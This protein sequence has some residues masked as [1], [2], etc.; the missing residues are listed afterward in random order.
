MI[1]EREKKII[2]YISKHGPVK[3]DEL[4]LVLKLS[5]R[6]VRISIAKIKLFLDSHNIQLKSARNIGYS[7]SN[8]HQKFVSILLLETDKTQVRPITKH[9]RYLYCISKLLDGTNIS[10]VELANTL[11]ISYNTLRNTKQELEAD[12]H[13][14]LKIDITDYQNV[15]LV[16]RLKILMHYVFIEISKQ[17]QVDSSQI[18]FLLG[19]IYNNYGFTKLHSIISDSKV[20]NTAQYTTKVA[21]IVIYYV[22]YVNDQVMSLERITTW[23]DILAILEELCNDIEL[24]ILNKMYV[25]LG[26][27]QADTQAIT[28][29]T[30]DVKYYFD[31]F[32]PVKNYMY[33]YDQSEVSHFIL[34]LVALMYRVQLNIMIEIDFAAKIKNKFPFSFYVAQ[35]LLNYLMS[36]T[37]LT[38]I[39]SE[40][41]LIALYIENNLMKKNYTSKV[42]IINDYG[43]SIKQ[44]VCNQ[45]ENRF[46]TQIEVVDVVT[47]HEYKQISNLDSLD[48]DLIISN[49]NIERNKIPNIRISPILQLTELEKISS[50]IKKHHHNLERIFQMFDEE[51]I[52]IYDEKWTFESII[53]NASYTLYNQGYITSMEEFEADV[54][55]REKVNSTYFGNG[56]II[57]HP[58]G[59]YALQNK[60]FV[61]KVSKELVLKRNNISMMF[62]LCISNEIDQSVS[63]L[64]DLIIEIIRNGELNDEL[65]DAK[66]ANEIAYIL[67]REISK[68]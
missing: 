32:T 46:G 4:S 58:I 40:I 55:T 53:S 68:L 23:N 15:E 43:N 64:Y 42:L 67:S 21:A 47:K 2:K 8:E 29:L 13:R 14:S 44:E 48:I 33:E 50:E 24:S 19:P 37:S 62:I 1:T 7:L 30:A 27:I 56:I 17:E 38:I 25:G 61:A 65:N 16:D 51:L 59:D 12:I 10:D 6:T 11:F 36:D 22:L 41:A 39:D 28:L 60:V 45:L 57:P 26:M 5:K 31:N 49:V 3:T 20:G 54:I 52:E 35:Q 18:K 63:L 66:T 9:E 34:H